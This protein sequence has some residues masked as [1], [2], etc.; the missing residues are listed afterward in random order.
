MAR[1]PAIERIDLAFYAAAAADLFM[2]KCPTIP[3]RTNW[4]LQLS[5]VI[6]KQIIECRGQ[7]APH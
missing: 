1:L 6:G 4:V 7:V 2:S 3:L 5:I